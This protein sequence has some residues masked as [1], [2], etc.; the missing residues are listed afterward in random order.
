LNV[1]QRGG[2]SLLGR[3]FHYRM[4]PLSVAELLNCEIPDFA[5]R[6]PRP[7]GKELMDQLLQ[8]GGF[9]EPFLKA[10]MRFFNRWK[11]LR[12][13]LL[14]R[15]DLRDLTRIQ[16]IG[17]IEILAELLRNQTGQLI[18]YSSLASAV[19]VSVDTI[20]RWLAALSSLY[21]C[22]LIR[23]W[24]KNIPKSL[25]KQPKVYLWDWST[26]TDRGARCENMVASHLLKAVH[27]W[28]DTGLGEYDLFFVRDKQKREVD[29][30][31]TNQKKPWFLA[32]VKSSASQTLTPHL[33]Y[34][35]NLIN[36]GHAFQICF[37]D[38]Y[39]DRDCFDIKEPVK[40]PAATFLS[41]L[42]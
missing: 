14:F 4:H 33:G 24:F 3:Y 35:M 18:N 22:F 28:N 23:P 26:L 9:P 25:R 39:K 12:T 32:E 16:E 17:Q 15:E 42:V 2:D 31:V 5:I 29:F 7:A 10:D 8:Y 34:Y 6:K 30:L 13:E 19:N 38:E 27:L 40:V 20:R 36:T 37:D 21:Y 41:Q 1:Y 11:R